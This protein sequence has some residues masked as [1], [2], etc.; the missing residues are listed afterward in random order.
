MS[1]HIQL[2][3]EA[4]EF[5]EATA[6]PPYLFELDPEKGRSVIDGVQAEPIDKPSVEIEDRLIDGGPIGRLSMRILRPPEARAP[7]PR[8]WHRIFAIQ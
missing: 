1:T 7:L 2:E 8:I 3:P 5:A 6:H 4:R